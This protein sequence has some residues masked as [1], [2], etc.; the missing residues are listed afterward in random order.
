MY[1]KNKENIL[2]IKEAIEKIFS[3]T[4]NISNHEEFHQNQIVF[5]AVMMNFVVIGEAVSRLTDDFISKNNHID[6]IKIKGLRN[7]IAHDY[8]GIDVEEIWQIVKNTI[9]EFNNQINEMLKHF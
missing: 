1:D 7:I 2:D 8:V 3:F 6:W 5:D 4:N 9:P